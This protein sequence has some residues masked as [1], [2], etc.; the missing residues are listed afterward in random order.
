VNDQFNDPGAQADWLK[1]VQKEFE[2]M[3]DRQNNLKELKN[4]IVTNTKM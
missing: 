4:Y 2:E 1:K 3:P